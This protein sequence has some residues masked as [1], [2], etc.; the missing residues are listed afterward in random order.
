MKDIVVVLAQR[1]D[2]PAKQ[3]RVAV[4]TYGADKSNIDNNSAQPFW[5]WFIENPRPQPSKSL[6]S[7]AELIFKP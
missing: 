6:H 3:P 4:E 5:T 2:L 7:P 1:K